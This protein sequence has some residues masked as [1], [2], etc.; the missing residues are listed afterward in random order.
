[1]KDNLFNNLS[2]EQISILPNYVQSIIQEMKQIFVGVDLN[3]I[4]DKSKIEI[5]ESYNEPTLEMSIIPINEHVDDI[6]LFA[7]KSQCI[8]GLFGVEYLECH[9]D[10]DRDITLTDEVIELIKKYLEGITVYVL[11]NNKNEIIR[12]K[13]DFGTN[14]LEYNPKSCLLGWL[15]PRYKVDHFEK[16]TFSFFKSV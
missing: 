4:S 7:S 14:S 8:L 10:A 11:Y 6:S 2:S 13:A 5:T 15:F 12:K 16:I 9:H 3:K 1:M